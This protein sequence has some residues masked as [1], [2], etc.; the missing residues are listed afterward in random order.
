MSVFLDEYA[1]LIH[2]VKCAIHDQQ[3]QE[4][5]DTLRFDKVY[6]YGEQ[7][8]IANIAFY[9]VQRLQKKPDA[10]LYSEWKLCCDM[11]F[12]RDINQ[13]FARDEIIAEFQK[14]NI[15]VLEVQGTELKKLYPQP[16][17]RTMS[18]IDF[19]IDEENLSKAWGILEKLGYECSDNHGVEVD[20]FRSPNINV[21]VHS[22]YFTKKS[23]Y[24]S[25]LRPPFTSVEETGEY[26]I[27]DF[28]LY[29]ILHVAK[30][31]FCMG[32]GIR[33]VLDV[34]YLNLNYS[35]VI[36]Q[37][38]VRSIFEKANVVEFVEEL[39]SLA[40]AWFEEGNL[41][42]TDMGNY[43]LGSGLHGTFYNSVNNELKKRHDDGV[44]L[45]RLRHV[46]RRFFAGGHIMY[47]KY[48]ILERWKILYPF[49]WLHRGIVTVFSPKRRLIKEEMKALAKSEWK[50][51]SR[52][53]KTIDSDGGNQN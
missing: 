35:Q 45:I 49:C 20:G 11:A 46:L 17:Y 8:Q 53:E 14:E 34:Y 4:L 52:E 22:Q 15:R 38:Y 40:N 42:R 13:S 3:P 47:D 10:Q 33:R 36:D 30:H 44:H 48:P 9:S 21:E 19:I 27:N 43:I 18:D 2:L 26:D 41:E 12:T 25:V 7:H 51:G 16:E 5:P 31:Y 28:Y 1:Y 39:S 37:T 50:Q 29:N 32:C 24:Y 6:Q 23:P